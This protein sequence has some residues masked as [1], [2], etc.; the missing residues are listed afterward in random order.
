MRGAVYNTYSCETTPESAQVNHINYKRSRGAAR[1]SEKESAMSIF[2]R[3][4]VYWFH[5]LYE[6]RHIQKSTGQ[7]GHRLLPD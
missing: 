2:K 7:L 3:G 1:V 5:F 6:G 4:N